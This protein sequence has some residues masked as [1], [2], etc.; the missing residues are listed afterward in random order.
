MTSSSYIVYIVCKCKK[1][2]VSVVKFQINLI[3]LVCSRICYYLC[4]NL[5]KYMAYAVNILASLMLFYPFVIIFA[6]YSG[7]HF[8]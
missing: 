7:K 3:L 5:R 6:E 1:H 4:S 8:P 2:F